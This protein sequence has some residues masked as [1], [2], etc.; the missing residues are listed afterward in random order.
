MGLER[1]LEAEHRLE[2]EMAVNVNA[3]V[4]S[5]GYIFTLLAEATGADL[6]DMPYYS[7]N[8]QD[9]RMYAGL[10]I[11]NAGGRPMPTVMEE[12]YGRIPFFEFPL[13]KGCKPWQVNASSM[14]EGYSE[15]VVDGTTYRIVECDDVGVFAG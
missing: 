13:V 3:S 4:T 12:G 14:N 8:V 1:R 10:V 11:Q 7:E 6:T 9:E 2:S 15:T 5:G